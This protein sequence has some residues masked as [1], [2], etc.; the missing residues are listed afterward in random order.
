MLWH[1][2]DPDTFERVGAV[3]KTNSMSWTRRWGS[4]GCFEME[5]PFAPEYADLFK[6][7]RLIS[8]GTE[9]GIIEYINLTR[10]DRGENL[11]CGGR[12][13]L[14]YL[15]RRL[16]L[17]TVSAAG[18]AE[19]VM[20]KLVSDNTTGDRAFTGLT[21]E[22]SQG[23]GDTVDYSGENANLLTELES[24]AALSNLNPVIEM[25]SGG[26]VFKVKQGVDRSASQ[27][28]N[29]RAIFSEAFDNVLSQ[30]YSKDT[31]NYSNFAYAGEKTLG[32]ATGRERR[33]LFV[34]ASGTDDEITTQMK[35][36]LAEALTTEAFTVEVNPYGNLKYKTDYDL[37]DTITV[38][39]KR[40]G[41]Q[42][43]AQITEITE[44]Y[45]E[46]GFTLEMTLGYKDSIKKILG[47]ML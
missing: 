22:A 19:A 26:M 21:V 47:R 11:V 8:N 36:A 38:A 18:T 29:P 10:D 31:A 37:G 34:S 20:K 24:L 44:S 12:F 23:L 40:W 32:T 46:D 33:E 25:S 27:S 3:E 16:V 28:V 42:V 39:S 13:L 35:T 17:G 30:D 15:S 9:A 2:Y 6:T 43:D 14:S 7:E 1:I 45:A 5:V 4:A 41:L